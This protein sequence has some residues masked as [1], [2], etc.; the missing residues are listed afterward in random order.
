[1]KAETCQFC[2]KPGD[3]WAGPTHQRALS[4][5]YRCNACGHVW[6]LAHDL[7]ADPPRSEADV[8]EEPV[9]RNVIPG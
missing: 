5:Y 4:R 9:P 8:T 3:E 1:M 6:S 2:N 7:A